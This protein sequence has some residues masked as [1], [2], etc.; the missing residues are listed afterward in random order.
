MN[1]KNVLLSTGRD[2]IPRL[3]YILMNVFVSR[4]F[5]IAFLPNEQVN[6]FV[7]DGAQ[8]NKTL[9]KRAIALAQMS[10]EEWKEMYDTDDSNNMKEN[11]AARIIQG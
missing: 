2:G 7:H 4:P 8:R 5:L 9:T 10:D 3:L 11:R 6:A 1:E